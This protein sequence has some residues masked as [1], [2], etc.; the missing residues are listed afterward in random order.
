MIRILLHI[1]RIF[2]FWVHI[3]VALIVRPKFL[4]AV[5][6]LVFD[7]QGSVL[8]FK[9]TYRKLAWGIPAGGL[10]HR[11]QPQ[12]AILREFFEE[13]SMT[14]EVQRL[15]LA[16]S[17]RYF[18]HV[19]L[20]YLCK[21]VAGEFKESHEISEIQYFDV[22]NLPPMLFD[23]KELICKVYKELFAVTV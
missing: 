1:W 6:A 14:I 9:H 12:D 10:E 7:Q 13:T 19:S 4:M 5:S 21:I 20:V 22:N 16:E 17:S 2:P 18:H 3:F 8:L 15:L 11:E 23:E